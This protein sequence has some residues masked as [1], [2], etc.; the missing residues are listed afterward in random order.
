[1]GSDRLLVIGSNSFSGSHFACSA[2]NANFEVIGI[3]RSERPNSVFL[4][5]RW[6]YA[7]LVEYPFYKIDLNGDLTELFE[8]MSDYKP[9]HVVNFAAQGMVAE[10]WKNPLDWYKTNVIAQIRLH[11]LL[12]KLDSLKKYIHVSTPEVYG[13][14]SGWISENYNFAP[15]TPYAASRAACDLHLLTYFKG[16]NFPVI[17]TRAAN[18]YGPGQ[19]LY[20]IIP[21]AILA[22][23]SGIKLDLHGGGLSERSFIHINDVASATLQI[24]KMGQLGE[25]YHISGKELISIKNLV[26][27]VA[28]IYG[29]SLEDLAI[30]GEER[31]GKDQA[32]KLGSDRIRSELNWREAM[33]FDMGL[34]ETVSWVDAN[35]EEFQNLKWHYEHKS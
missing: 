25:T 5:D 4:P 28:T 23:T 26:G 29:K 30:I 11:D 13:S 34:N 33:P 20:R 27:K 18:V 7:R 10:S 21:R 16:H 32:Y 24:C 9:T 35:F 8:L 15:S 31:L 19:Q 22:A 6:H 3:S 17:F 2:V 14:N 12:R 1:M